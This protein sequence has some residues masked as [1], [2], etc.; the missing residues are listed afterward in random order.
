MFF[1]RSCGNTEI[2]FKPTKKFHC[3][4]WDLILY[5]PST[6]DWSP[7]SILWSFIYYPSLICV[8]SPYKN[9]PFLTQQKYTSNAKGSVIKQGTKKTLHT[10][11]TSLKTS[12]LN[13][14][15]KMCFLFY[16]TVI[17]C[18]LQTDGSRCSPSSSSSSSI[19]C[20]CS[21]S[22]HPIHT[23]P[24]PEKNI[25]SPCYLSVISNQSFIFSLRQKIWD[26]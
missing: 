12:S 6:D 22:C 1:E 20:L 21:V 8:S 10:L 26:L 11:Q 19:T 25:W 13:Q 7:V 9:V 15:N 24:W 2:P 23:N 4:Q 18:S 17:C 16:L 5:T 3:I 14:E